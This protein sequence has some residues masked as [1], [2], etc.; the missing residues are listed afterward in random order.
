MLLLEVLKKNQTFS[1]TA[2]YGSTVRQSLFLW[3]YP[4]LVAAL[5]GMISYSCCGESLLE[6]ECP[7]VNVNPT[8]VVDSSFY[9]KNTKDSLNLSH[10]H[11]H[12]FQIQG[13]IEYVCNHIL[14]SC[15]GPL[16]KWIFIRDYERFESQSLTLASWSFIFP[17]ALHGTMVNI[18]R[19]R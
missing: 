18:L 6:T 3:W 16:T 5:N 2:V 19:E 14:M 4:Q 10:N 13:Q 12:Y 15:V 11:K 9:L 8:N 17:H 7:T 1:Q